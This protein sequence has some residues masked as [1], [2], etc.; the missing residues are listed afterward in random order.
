MTL[1][2]ASSPNSAEI[3]EN[4]KLLQILQSL[5]DKPDPG[6]TGLLCILQIHFWIF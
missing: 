4:C 2:D 3:L 6:G 1:H 5:P